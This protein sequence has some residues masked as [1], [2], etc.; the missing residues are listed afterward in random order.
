MFGHPRH[1]DVNAV[2]SEQRPELRVL[3]RVVGEA[4]QQDDRLR[5]AL[6]VLEQR[7]TGRRQD[8]CVVERHKGVRAFER[9]G[10]AA[11]GAAWRR[12]NHPSGYARA[13]GFTR[14]AR[15]LRAR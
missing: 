7:R 15:L 4:V 9:L 6:P 2:T 11:R 3:C 1:E 10:V 8:A 5:R 12:C 14:N 13:A